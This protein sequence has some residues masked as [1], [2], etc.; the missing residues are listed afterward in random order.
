MTGRDRLGW[1]GRRTVCV[2][3]PGFPVGNRGKTAAWRGFQVF[4]PARRGFALLDR[5]AAPTDTFRVVVND[6]SGTSFEPSGGFVAGLRLNRL[7]DG[8]RPG[9]QGLARGFPTGVFISPESRGRGLV[10]ECRLE[11]GFV[12]E[13]FLLFFG[14]ELVAGFG[15][16]CPCPV[17]KQPG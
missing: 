7:W 1:G 16:C 3:A 8:S 11:D 5:S 13:G 6:D 17:R 14:R 15:R 10:S 9:S 4:S 12:F 2:D